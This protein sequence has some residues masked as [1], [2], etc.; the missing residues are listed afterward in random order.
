MY[1]FD[2][3]SLEWEVLRWRRLKLNLIRALGLETLKEFL[4][5]TLNYYQYREHFAEYFAEVLQDNLPEDQRKDAQSLARKSAQRMTR[6]LTTKSMKCWR[7]SS[8]TWTTSRTLRGLAR[9]RISCKSMGEANQMPSHWSMSFLSGSGKSVDTF[10]ADALVEKL[11]D[12][13]RIDH[14]TTIAEKRRNA[15]LYEIDR[16]RAVL[17]KSLRRSVQEIEDRE[18]KV[19]ED[20]ANK[21]KNAA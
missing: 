4:S 1:V 13:E 16:R 10:M 17:G 3:V 21:G 15:S 12:I 11:N 14:L 7:A 8:W 19:I 6:T 5:E 20:D 2:V 9:Q 18:F